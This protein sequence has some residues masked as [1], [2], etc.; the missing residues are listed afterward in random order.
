MKPK[1]NETP[2]MMSLSLV[3]RKFI[4]LLTKDGKKVKATTLFFK[5]CSDIK[6]QSQ[7]DGDK[8][9]GFHSSALESKQADPSIGRILS[10]A[11]E[12]V[13]PNVEVRKVRRAGT[14]YHVPALVSVKKQESLA[15]KWLIQGAKHRKKNSK[16]PFSHCLASEIVEAS[17]KTG[18]ARLKRDELHRLAE[19]NRAYIRYRWW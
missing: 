9:Y 13:K 11:I 19:A 10:Q 17:K 15:V 14:T 7:Q 6:K 1:M 4:N 5:M 16:F 2:I 12:N 18:Q 8:K 3:C